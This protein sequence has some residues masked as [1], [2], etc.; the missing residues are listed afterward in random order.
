MNLPEGILDL[1]GRIYPTWQKV[2][3]ERHS[4]QAYTLWIMTD[5]QEWKF[6]RACLSLDNRWTLSPAY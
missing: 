2:G 6:W 4:D 3:Y 1:V 5:D